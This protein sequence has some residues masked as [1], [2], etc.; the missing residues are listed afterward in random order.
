MKTKL[1]FNPNIASEVFNTAV[2][3]TNEVVLFVQAATESGADLETAYDDMRMI[4]TLL[5]LKRLHLVVHGQIKRT[6]AGHLR[7]GTS[8]YDAMD[9]V[10]NGRVLHSLTN[11]KQL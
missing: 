8:L 4:D 3:K 1:N 10:I 7:K 2:M 9:G 11:H 5:H 6:K